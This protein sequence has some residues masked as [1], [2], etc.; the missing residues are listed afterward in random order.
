MSVHAPLAATDRL[1][2]GLG[3][4]DGGPARAGTPVWLLGLIVLAGAIYGAFMGSFGLS[5]DRAPMV[6]YAAAKMP[7]L[8]LGTTLVCMPGFL[9]L[10]TV[11][12]LRDDFPLAL[13]A[14]LAGQAAVT[15]ALAS[16]G[17]I[18]A[19]MYISGLS[20]RG[21]LLFNAAMFTL[22]TAAAQAVM[23]RRYRELV[24]RDE[25]HHLMLW[26]WAL[27]YIFVGIQMG[28]MLRPFVGSPDIPVAFLREEPFTNA[29]IVVIRLF[30]GS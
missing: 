22:A 3:G 9:A 23:R 24:R 14:V 1:I 12:G 8:I 2:K 17:P 5:T 21:A 15:V 29:Y 13:R 4:A 16:L 6:L 18:T 27:L 28:W 19:L 7:I 30:F 10:N 11:L 25:R 20:H 26:T